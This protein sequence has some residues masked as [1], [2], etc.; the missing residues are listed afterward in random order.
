MIVNWA[1][2]I[3]DTESHKLNLEFGIGIGIGTGIRF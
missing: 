1:L 3:F 2:G